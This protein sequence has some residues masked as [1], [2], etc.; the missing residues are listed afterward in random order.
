MSKAIKQMQMESLKKDFEGV[1]DLVVLSVKGIN[2]TVDN[3]LRQTLRKKNIRLQVV[4][5]SLTRRVFDEMGLRVNKDSPYWAGPTLMAWGASSI[6]EL[7]QALDAE[8]N[9]GKTAAQFKD[10][11]TIKGAISDGQEI[12]FQQALK[13]PTRLEAIARVIGLALAP[14][15]RLL[16]QITGPASQLASQIKQLSEK[17][18]EEGAPAAEAAPAAS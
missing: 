3:Q 8:L 18:P 6:A 17:K 7:S 1:R 14:A 2:A 16:G 9:K 5:N 13:M 15:S 10:K 11:V 4:K 12:T